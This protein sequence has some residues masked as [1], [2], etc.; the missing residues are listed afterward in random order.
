MSKQP[1]ACPFTAAATASASWESAKTAPASWE[2][3]K[4]AAHERVADAVPD[5]PVIP[6]NSEAG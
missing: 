3:A 4:I 5:A 6:T 2:N 1:C